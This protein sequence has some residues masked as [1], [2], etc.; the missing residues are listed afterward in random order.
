M[1]TSDTEVDVRLLGDWQ[2]TPDLRD[3]AGLVVVLAHMVIWCTDSCPAATLHSQG[4]VPGVD[5]RGLHL[6]SDHP[7]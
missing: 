6:V 5:L 3:V 7:T 1:C 4:W 2:A